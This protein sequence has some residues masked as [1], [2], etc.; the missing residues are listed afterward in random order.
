MINQD[1]IQDLLNLSNP[2]N[3]SG[4]K[5]WVNDGGNMMTAMN[6]YKKITGQEF[7]LPIPIGGPRSDG[8][9]MPEGA[10]RVSKGLGA[11]FAVHTETVG[12]GKHFVECPM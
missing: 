12:T 10:A 5:M 8:G 11:A 1:H 6:W 7:L 3:M 2:A 9:Q 4:R